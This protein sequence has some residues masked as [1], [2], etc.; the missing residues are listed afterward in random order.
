MIEDYSIFN[1]SQLSA[2]NKIYSLSY[3]TSRRYCDN[4]DAN[5]V[6]CVCEFTAET[7]LLLLERREKYFSRKA[8]GS[9]RA[10][11][12]LKEVWNVVPC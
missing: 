2:E 8:E 5:V 9:S 3:F 12:P 11:I 10:F 7:T 1:K 6:K 4:I